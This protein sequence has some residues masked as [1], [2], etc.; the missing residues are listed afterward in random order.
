MGPQHPGSGHMRLIAEVD[1]DIIVAF[2]PNIGY[3]HRAVEKIAETKTYLQIIPLVERPMLP[4]TASANLGY[5]LALEKL[6][7]VEVP[8]RAQ[9]L[10]ML[11]C[12]MSRIHSHLYGLG[13]FGN[14]IGSSTVFEW[15]FADRE[16]FLELTQQ[17]TGARLTASFMVPGG[18]RRDLPQDF[19]DKAL[20]AVAYM[21]QRLK[22]YDKIFVNNP[23]TIARLEGVG[24]IKKS[25]AARIGIVGPNLRAS[26]VAY[27]VR[28]IEPYCAYGDLDFDLIVREE[29]DC[30]ARLLVR[31]EEIKQ[32]IKLIRQIL[33]KLPSGSFFAEKYLKL[34]TP[35]MKELM[36]KSNILRFPAVFSALKPAKGDAISRVEAGR[37]ELFYYIVSDGTAQPYRFRMVTPSFKNVIA[38][39]AALLGGRL[40]DVPSVYGSLDYFPPEADR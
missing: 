34:I 36:D 33:D 30:Y 9:Y 13:I 26:G 31:R 4:D 40:A 29:G 19:K 10:R 21:E 18:I 28:K 16:P 20:K 23:V 5:I 6:L 32:S 17:W 12:E 14:M 27:D 35:K 25:E 22:D 2:E 37:G 39:K 1:G 7:D 11:L 8:P 38:F 15:A 24:V 3:V